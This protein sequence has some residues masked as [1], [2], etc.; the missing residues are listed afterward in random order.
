[1][2][3]DHITKTATYAFLGIDNNDNDNDN[4][5]KCKNCSL[6]ILLTATDRKPQ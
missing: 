4:N 5:N 1:M 2:I 3:N 6:Y